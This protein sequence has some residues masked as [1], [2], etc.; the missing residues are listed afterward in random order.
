M[1]LTPESR[2]YS[3]LITS[4]KLHHFDIFEKRGFQLAIL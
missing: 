1:V 3:T 4:H 2:C